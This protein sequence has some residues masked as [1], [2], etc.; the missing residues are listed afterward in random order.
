MTE[1]TEST[2][3]H[4]GSRWRMAAWV[5]AA[6]A[7]LLPFFAMQLKDEIN[8]TGSDFAFAGLLIVGSGVLLEL[9]A[10]M[11]ENTAYRAAFGVGIATAFLLIWINA[12]VGIIGSEDNPA[13]LMHVGVLAIGIIGA[14]IARFKPAGMARALFATAFAQGL[15]GVIA[16]AAGLG[17]TAPSF[18]EAVVFL[19]GF[20]TALWLLS[21]S[22][23]RKA[24]QAQ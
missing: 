5:T 7:W 9:I 8:W 24:A 20:F 4:G 12:A 18:P 22:L 10:R 15:I 11:T 1:K 14:V 3:K 17:S 6:I 21:A 2:G 16:L 19:T 13:N 23:F